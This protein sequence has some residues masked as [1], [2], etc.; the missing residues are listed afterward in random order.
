MIDTI[1]N[2]PRYIRQTDAFG[3]QG[4]DDPNGPWRSIAPPQ[5]GAPWQTTS[6]L[7]ADQPAS[8]SP[9][10]ELR[11]ASADVSGVEILS[12]AAQAVLDAAEPCVSPEEPD[13][14]D[15]LMLAA[16]IRQVDGTNRLGAA[17]LAEAIMSHPASRWCNC[18]IGL[19]TASP[20][21]R[22][23]TKPLSPAA[24]AIYEA[25]IE[26]SELPNDA[27]WICVYTLRA[28]AAQLAYAGAPEASDWLLQI[29]TELEETSG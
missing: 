3:W 18:N 2:M 9:M 23:M 22:L 12:P 5:S 8:M 14:D 13:A 1:R 20:R 11:Q 27:E 26:Q 7:F 10:D 17:A 19:N 29:A 6:P 24:Q 25:A 15:I 28:A 4:A 21:S 16:I